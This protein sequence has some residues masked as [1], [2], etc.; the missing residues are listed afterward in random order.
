MAWRNFQAKIWKKSKNV[1]CKIS[2]YRR[3][4]TGLKISLDLRLSSTS[5]KT[6]EFML[7]LLWVNLRL[8]IFKKDSFGLVQ[9]A[10][11]KFLSI[12]CHIEVLSFYNKMIMTMQVCRLKEAWT[13]LTS[14]RMKKMRNWIWMRMVS[15]LKKNKYVKMTRILCCF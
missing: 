13:I 1:T 10:I 7:L 14:I 4:R 6:G 2:P 8:L 9:T 5:L 15:N 3:S 12:S 11:R